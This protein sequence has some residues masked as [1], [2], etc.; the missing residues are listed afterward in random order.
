MFILFSYQ[1]NNKILILDCN[2]YMLDFYITVPQ[3]IDQSTLLLYL[4]ISDW[5]FD[6]I[7]NYIFVIQVCL[8][9]YPSIISLYLHM[10][11]S[12]YNLSIYK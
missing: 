12:I 8:S 3:V 10:Y 6:W 2:V 7:A 1:N 5:L 4:K 9:I 11:L